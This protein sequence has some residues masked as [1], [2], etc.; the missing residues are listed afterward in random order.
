MRNAAIPLVTGLAVTL[1][2]FLVL[3]TFLIASA[4]GSGDYRAGAPGGVSA[5]S[6]KLFS[7]VVVALACAAGAGLAAR[8]M[9]RADIERKGA[10][11]VAPAATAPVALGLVVNGLVAGIGVGGPLLVLVAA[12]VGTGLGAWIGSSR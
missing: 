12:A 4:L 8:G 6:L 3:Q 7:L 5:G 9:R 2:V 10:L 11:R 1:I